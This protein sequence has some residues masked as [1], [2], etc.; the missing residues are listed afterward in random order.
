MPVLPIILASAGALWSIYVSIRANELRLLL[1]SALPL[2]L[3]LFGIAG[4]DVVSSFRPSLQV[5]WIAIHLLT[6]AII[7]WSGRVLEERRRMAENHANELAQARLESDA[8]SRLKAEF[9]ANMNHEIRTPLTS[10]IGFSSLLIDEVNDAHRSLINVIQRSGTRLLETLDSILDLAMLESGAMKLH[11]E[12]LDLAE[13]AQLHVDRFRKAAKAKDLQIR[14]TFEGR[15]EAFVDRACVGRIFSRLIDNAVKFT[16]R[17]RITVDVSRQNGH[18]RVLVRD[19]G[20]GIDRQFIP[21]VF[22]DFSQES[23]GTRRAF[24]GA[25][26]GL[27]VTK[28]LVD[29]LGGTILVESP[30]DSGTTFIVTLPAADSDESDRTAVTAGVVRAEV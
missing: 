20:I 13:E 28:R 16:D 24:E 21:H 2:L 27:A 17:G 22:D 12:R 7:V 5:V 23:T 30:F 19:T 14:V 1:L 8:M 3:L 26:L 15:T 18:V 9:L 29:L 11:R 6:L 4:F 10:I 25:G